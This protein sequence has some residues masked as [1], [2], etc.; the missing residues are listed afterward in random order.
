MIQ[1]FSQSPSVWFNYAHFLHQTISSPERARLLLPRATQALP[2]HTHIN[3]TIK[4]AALEFR[5]QNGSPE[6]GRTIF[7]GLLSTFPKRLDIW[8]Q[9]LDLEVQQNDHETVRALFER[10][11]KMKHLRPK[12]AK[13]WFK[14]WSDWETKNG[15]SKSQSKV[16][17]KAEQWVKDR[18]EM[19]DSVADKNE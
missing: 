15:D 19:K 6:R 7:E 11:V 13:A 8:N 3:L 14:R 17:V 5:S 10:V 1:K 2:Q 12:G 4:F 9:F 16:R 18:A